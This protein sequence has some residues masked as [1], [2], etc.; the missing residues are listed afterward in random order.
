M[1][2]LDM[3]CN[4]FALSALEMLICSEKHPVRRANHVYAKKNG[5]R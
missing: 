3:E 4:D 5:N 2:D 1:Y